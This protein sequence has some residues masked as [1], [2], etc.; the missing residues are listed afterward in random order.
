MNP[1]GFPG[2]P[3]RLQIGAALLEAAMENM[4]N[5]AGSNKQQRVGEE[6]NLSHR[7]KNV[8]F[9]QLFL[10]CLQGWGPVQGTGA[11][12]NASG[13]GWSHY[14]DSVRKRLWL[15]KAEVS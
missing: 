9:L 2:F 6:H 5:R 14:D 4:E 11:Q 1:R 13:P 15:L 8:S 10:Q 12:D 3:S 7:H